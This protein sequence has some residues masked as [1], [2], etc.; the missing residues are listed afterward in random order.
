[1]EVAGGQV[2]NKIAAL[3]W[4]A[5]GTVWS[6]GHSS[7]TVI[8][9][10]HGVSLL[11]AYGGDLIAGGDVTHIRRRPNWQTALAPVGWCNSWRAMGKAVGGVPIPSPPR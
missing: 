7:C 2:V 5:C 11:T 4:H 10:Q 8:K 6:T 3:G 1:M 9:I